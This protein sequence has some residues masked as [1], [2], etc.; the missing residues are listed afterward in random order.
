MKL[1]LTSIYNEKIFNIT[2]QIV[3][4]DKVKF[5]R[6]ET[7]HSFLLYITSNIIVNSGKIK[8]ERIETN[9]SF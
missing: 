9:Y 4:L 5:E 3:N 6:I 7:N 1:Q 8:Y 2:L